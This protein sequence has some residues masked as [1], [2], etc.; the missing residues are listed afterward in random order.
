MLEN[1]TEKLQTS[2]DK[3]STLRNLIIVF[4]ITGLI[5]ALLYRFI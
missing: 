3:N 4:F 1:K 5:L 2:K